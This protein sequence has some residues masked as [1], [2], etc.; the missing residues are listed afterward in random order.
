MNR[1]ADGQNKANGSP[2]L[3][4]RKRVKVKSSVLPFERRNTTCCSSKFVICVVFFV[5]RVVLLLI[6]TFYVLLMC[7]CVLPPG[8]NP[9]AVDKYVNIN[10]SIVI[11]VLKSYGTHKYTVWTQCRICNVQGCTERSRPWR[12]LPWKSWASVGVHTGIERTS[13]SLSASLARDV[14]RHKF[15]FT[16]RYTSCT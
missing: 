15:D 1:R 10:I 14:E 6:V 2:S 4:M 16:D 3:F 12:W 11:Y 5:I 13:V 9:I 7:K 8:V